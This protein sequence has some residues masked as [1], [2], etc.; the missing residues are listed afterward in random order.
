MTEN[1]FLC[2]NCIYL[3]NYTGNVIQCSRLGRRRNPK[4]ECNYFKK[5]W[6]GGRNE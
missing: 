2:Y 6:T 1:P 4:T 5:Q 3:T